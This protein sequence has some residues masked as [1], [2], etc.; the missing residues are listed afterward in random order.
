MDQTIQI[1][2][3]E[4][5]GRLQQINAPGQA[6]RSL[7]SMEISGQAAALE[8]LSDLYQSFQTAFVRYRQLLGQDMQKASEAIK[9]LEEADEGIFSETK[10]S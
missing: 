6:A 2:T 9:E 7:S 4:I 8:E 10:R 1:R 5:A 3:G